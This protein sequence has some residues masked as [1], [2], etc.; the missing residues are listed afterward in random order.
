MEALEVRHFAELAGQ[1]VEGEEEKVAAPLEV[2]CYK[3]MIFSELS[4]TPH[5][6]E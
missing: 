3:W 2:G 4:P 1:E 5:F 6:Q